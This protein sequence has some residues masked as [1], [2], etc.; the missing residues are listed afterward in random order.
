MNV[1]AAQLDAT[2][3]PTTDISNRRKHESVKLERTSRQTPDDPYASPARNAAKQAVPCARNVL[4]QP[5]W[6]AK[7]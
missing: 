7:G 1:P 2:K 6:L 3:A 4:N 5:E